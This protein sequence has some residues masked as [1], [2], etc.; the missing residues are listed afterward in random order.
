MRT[1]LLVPVTYL[2]ACLIPGVSRKGDD[3]DDDDDDDEDD[4]E[5][6]DDDSYVRM[7][8]FLKR[9]GKFLRQVRTAARHG[10]DPHDGVAAAVGGRALGGGDEPP[11]HGRARGGHHRAAGPR[12][13]RR[14][15]A[16]PQPA[17]A[18]QLAA[19][20]SHWSCR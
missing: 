19:R 1:G 6:D 17:G 2:N 18:P 5:D 7:H 20:S 14:A 16:C 9:K 13:V 10:G 12:K 11:L 4:D 8:G 15:G 3:D